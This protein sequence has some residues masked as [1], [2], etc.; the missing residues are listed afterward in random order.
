M[1]KIVITT[2][3][4]VVFKKLYTVLYPQSCERVLNGSVLKTDIATQ[5]QQSSSGVEVV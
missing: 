5:V 1:N 2:Q 4:N 3:V